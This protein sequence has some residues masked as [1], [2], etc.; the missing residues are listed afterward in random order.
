MKLR[1][2]IL[3]ISLIFVAFSCSME[4]DTIM[5]DVENGIAEES[6]MFTAI[7]FGLTTSDM[8]TKSKTT[9]GAADS[10]DADDKEMTV[11]SYDIF[12]LEDNNV[13]GI[14]RKGGDVSSETS[15]GITLKNSEF[16]TKYK[17]GRTIT[18]YV[19]VNATTYKSDAITD[20]PFNTIKIGDSKEDIEQTEIF[21]HLTAESLVKV[22]ETSFI[23]DGTFPKSKS[24]NVGSPKS[25]NV[26]VKHVAARL[27]FSKFNVI[28]KGGVVEEKNLNP[29][30]VNLLA[31]EF[32][33]IQEKGLLN[34]AGANAF[35]KK[36]ISFKAEQSPILTAYSYRNDGYDD[37]YVELYIKFSVEYNGH[38]KEYEKTYVVNPK[39]DNKGSVL[40]G[41]L[42]KIVVNMEVSPKWVDANITLT[43]E[44]WFSHDLGEV[45]L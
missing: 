8:T 19:V 36:V 3:A 32:R 5:N 12:L 22:G 33:N 23:I 9:V 15:D 25:I 10:Q 16:V 6:E 11:S 28:D 45:D 7:N 38:A 44:D 29:C 17:D 1:N 39:S 2:I 42:Y 40:G 31:A 24:V 35:S 43:T 30:T 41:N 13:I 34:G 21:G 27:E 18:A 37:Q 4:D 20:D 26:E 14:I